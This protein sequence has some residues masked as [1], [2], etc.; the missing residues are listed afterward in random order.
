MREPTE[1]IRI[2]VP[3]LST[4]KL[5]PLVLE[6]DGFDVTRLVAREPDRLVFKPP[7]PLAWGQHQL[8][9]VERAANGEIL[10]R[11]KWTLEIRKSSAFREARLQ[12]NMVLSVTQRTSNDDLTP[13]TPA[14]DL[15]AGAAQFQGVLA[16]ADWRITGQADLLHNSQEALMPRSYNHGRVDIGRYLFTGAQGPVSAAIG[17]QS[18]GTDGLIMQGFN[19]RGV[20]ARLG[21]QESRISLT[22][23]SLHA[24][25]I[26]GFHEGLGISSSDNRV[27]GVVIGTRPVTPGRDGMAVS[28]T[29]LSGEGPSQSGVGVGGDATSTS[30]RAGSL[31]V[32]GNTLNQRLRLRGEYAVTYYDFDGR[33][34]DTDGDGVIDSN[35]PGEGDR[36]YSFLAVYAP[37]RDKT[38]AG[39]PLALNIGIESKR[40]GT[41]F[42]SPANPTGIADRELLRG[43]TSLRWSGLDVQM[44]HGRETDNVNNQTL[45]PRIRT[46][47]NSLSVGY[48]PSLPVQKDSALPPPKLA[49]YGRPFY[50][51]A[52]LA[53]D[54]DVTQ[55]GGSLSTGRLHATRN[56]SLSANFAYP[57]W[58][59]SVG[60]VLGKDD[61]FTNLASDTRSRSTQL[62][63]NMRLGQKLTIGPT[64]QWNNIEDRDNR[65]RDSKTLNTGLNLGYAFTQ[66]LS[67]NLGYNLY[68]RK[69]ADDSANTRTQDITGQLRWTAIQTQGARPGVAL[70]L[71]G[72]Y[73]DAGDRVTASNNRSSYQVFLK[74]AI[75]WLPSY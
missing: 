7:Q 40:L 25:D 35:L 58:S 17:H 66:R 59:W 6:L 29:Y 39:K 71:E 34:R 72:Q 47:L 13:P 75:S 21:T 74:A 11:G 53:M 60:H 33:G 2:A 28:A 10:E 49:W 8:R 68:R 48:A 24:Q 56:L 37:W 43:F 5:E 46:Y 30:G 19:R 64:V 61:D 44:S 3:A 55:A 52:L 38:V 54:Q 16:D 41:Y 15:T 20:S 69:V 1:P 51:A 18:V 45:L 65:S 27:D 63:A 57:M 32:D 50:N 4:D 67:G 42:R 36:A 31:V 12:S 23:F 26:I 73:S 62:S 70:S 22:G 9:L 14:R